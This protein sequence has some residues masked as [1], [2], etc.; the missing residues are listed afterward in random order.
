MNPGGNGT[1]HTHYWLV[2]NAAGAADAP[3]LVWQQGGPGGSS[4][5]GF[6]TENG[7]L[8]LNDFSTL[9]PAFNK[10]GVPTVFE[11]PRSWHTAPANVLYVEHPAPTGFSYCDPGPCYW[12]DRSQA[13]TSYAFYVAFFEAYP[14]LAHNPFY[15]S[16]ESYAGVLVPTASLQI[17]AHRTDA[18][19]DVAPWSLKGFML[20]NDC[21]GNRVFTCTPYS[22][23]IGAQVA[24]DFRFRHGMISEALYAQINEA[25]EGEWGTYEAPASAECRALLEDPIE[26]TWKQSGDTNSMGGGY[27]VYDTCGNDLLALGKGGKYQYAAAEEG[28]SVAELVAMREARQVHTSVGAGGEQVGG[29]GPNAGGDQGWYPDS[30]QYACGQ[31]AASAAWL[32]LD[33]VREAI[34]VQSREEAGRPFSF[35]TGLN[36][37]FNIFSLVGNYSSTLAPNLR[38]LQY[39]GD[40]DP[41]VPYIGT[42][43]WIAS[44]KFPVKNAWRPWPQNRAGGWQVAGYVTEYEVPGADHTF[45]F[46]T[47]RDAG[48]MVPRYKSK[49][50][51][52][53]I[54]QFLK[55]EP[56]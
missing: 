47:V 52:H 15:M 6:F 11:N 38:I 31:E 35:S 56:L 33:A 50:A 21:P 8:T 32:N 48:H 4:L 28:L 5:I 24:V 55:D 45:T 14:E 51:L 19:R 9:T 10:T 54:T 39:S 17:L 42:E 46:A 40:A 16:G 20:G 37:T 23:W 44:M 2:M 53:L 27:F 26:P 36:Y 25:C 49:E 3:T 7:P 43:R 34:H 12:D 1:V 29:V 30:G 18:N 13:L 22:G 41:C